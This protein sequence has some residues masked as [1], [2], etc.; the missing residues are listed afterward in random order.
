MDS[1]KIGRTGARAS[2]EPDASDRSRL[3]SV[4]FSMVLALTLLVSGCL[5]HDPLSIPPGPETPPP[6]ANLYVYVAEG[7]DEALENFG[8]AV[9][10]YPL[11]A[12]G[13]FVEGPATASLPA[14]NPRRLTV[15]PELDVLYVLTRNQV[16]AFDITGGGLRSLCQTPDTELRPPCATAPRPGSNPIDLT[17][18]QADT[19]EWLL[20]VVEGGIPGDNALSTRVSAFPLDERGGLPEFAGTVARNPDSLAFRGMAFSEIYLFA[21][22]GSLQRIDRFD[23][24]A[25]GALPLLIPTPTPFGQPSPTPTVAP[26]P[27]PP[28]QTPAPTPIPTPTPPQWYVPGPQRLRL[29]VAVQE[30]LPRQLLYMISQNARRVYSYPLT[31]ELDIED[32]SAQ[33]PRVDGLYED[34]LL[35]PQNRYI[36]ATAFQMGRIDSFS[37]TADGMIDKSTSSSTLDNPA[38]YPGG[39]AWLTFT[40]AAGEVQNRVFV[41]QGGLNRVD[42]FPVD[43]DGSLI[44]EPATSSQAKDYSFPTDIAIFVDD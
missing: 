39:M 2:T 11:G 22:D 29:G 38:S 44:A 25:D 19:G 20:Y 36:H 10:V 37:L 42:A 23:V 6:G 7:R 21:T 28:D 14:T 32:D 3:M 26:T 18:R 34:I 1:R 27:T 5:T 8:G 9:S 4:P 43:A 13:E 15:H 24:K 16:R 17:V 12:N 30:S 41:A 31:D 33:T 40:D 35:D